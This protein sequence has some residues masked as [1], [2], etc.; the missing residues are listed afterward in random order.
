MDNMRKMTET[1]TKDGDKAME[2]VREVADTAWKKGRETW[3]DLR[4]QGKEAMDGIQKNA[5]EAWED[6]QELVQKHPGKSLGIALLVGAVIGALLT[7]RK[8]D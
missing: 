8:N 4:G 1:L 6:T 5:E 3:K 7:F 2:R